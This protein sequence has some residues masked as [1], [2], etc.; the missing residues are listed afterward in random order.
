MRKLLLL[1]TATLALVP[2]AQAHADALPIEMLGKWCATTESFSN[3][4]F[5]RSKNCKHEDYSLTIK[6]NSIEYWESGCTFSSIAPRV[7]TTWSYNNRGRL[8]TKYYRVFE[9]KAKCGGEGENW[10]ETM[11]L[12]Y[13]P[14]GGTLKHQSFTDNELPGD[15]FDTETES[16]ETT[17]TPTKTFCSESYNKHTTYYESK[18]C[19]SNSVALYFGKDRYTISYSGEG[20]GFCRFATIKTVWDPNLGVATKTAGGPATYITASCPKGMMTLKLYNSKGSWY[21]EEAN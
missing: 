15:L 7:Q 6:R 13:Y 10:N 2:G 14:E 9:V 5:E 17:S 11:F 18:D 16:A 12:S 19:E 21:L 20:R 1:A 3:A 4:L 8:E